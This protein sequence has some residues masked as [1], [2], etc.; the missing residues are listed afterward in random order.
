MTS[1]NFLI[2]PVLPLQQTISAPQLTNPPHLPHDVTEFFSKSN[3]IS[4]KDYERFA[5]HQLLI[6]AFLNCKRV[7]K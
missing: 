6:L 1:Q 2:N 7:Q 3:L 4:P 5:A